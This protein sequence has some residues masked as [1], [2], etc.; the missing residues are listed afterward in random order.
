QGELGMVGI[1]ENFAVDVTML[2]GTLDAAICRALIDEADIDRWLSSTA[3][4]T[5]AANGPHALPP[6]RTAES[7]RPCRLVGA[8]ERPRFAVI[9]D[10]VLALRLFYRLAK[11]LP[12]TREGA[13][14][15]GLKPL[16][17]CV[18]YLPGEGT[19]AHRDP[20]RETADGQRSQL[21]VL[22]FLN[23]DFVGGAIEFPSLG[24]IFEPRVGRAIVFPHGVVHRDR[25]VERGRKFV[26]EAEV[27]Y[28]P[29]WQPY[30][31]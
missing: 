24:R 28:S 1:A 18:R 6:R 23:D 7:E 17:R 5:R 8:E 12:A 29:H 2:D 25:P 3:E 16:L 9:D 4:F 11:V 19:E 26:L 14:L 30:A 20:I 27:F 31:R 15:V 10:P 22:V 13:E 21:S